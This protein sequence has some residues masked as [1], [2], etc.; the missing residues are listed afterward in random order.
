M[1]LQLKTKSVIS[2]LTKKE[3]SKLL[4]ISDYKSVSQI[5]AKPRSAW[6]SA[7][8]KDPNSVISKARVQGVKAH[9]ALEVAIIESRTPVAPASMPRPM[10][11]PMTH[12]PVLRS[13]QPV[14]DIPQ[15]T[16]PEPRVIETPKP[17][18]AKDLLIEACLLAFEKDILVD[19]DE[20]WGQEE[21]LAHPLGYKGRFDGVGIFR[22]KLTIFDHKRTNVRKTGSGLQSF[23]K[24]LAAYKQAHEH[25]YPQHAIEQVA[26][27]NIFGKTADDVGTKVTVLDADQLALHLEYFNGRVGK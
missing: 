14:L 2:Y 25:L 26:V 7:Q 16:K 20:V 21:W 4:P 24:Q 3:I 22:G 13:P 18:P 1:K 23:Y 27:F 9:K 15:F 11:P 5:L 10:A 17:A 19:L 6:L 12:E 8:Y